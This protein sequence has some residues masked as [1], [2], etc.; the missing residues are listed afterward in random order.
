[1]KT[2]IKLE[3]QRAWVYR[4]SYRPSTN[5]Y[6]FIKT[7]MVVLVEGQSPYGASHHPYARKKK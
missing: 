3:T 1:M 4:R 5:I 6:H 2:Q 7:V